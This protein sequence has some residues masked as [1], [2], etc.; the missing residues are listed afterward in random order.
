M[1]LK[2]SFTMQDLL[3]RRCTAGIDLGFTHDLTALSLW[4]PPETEDEK[5]KVLCWYWLPEH[6]AD[7]PRNRMRSE[8]LRWAKDPLARLELTPG[9]VTDHGYLQTRFRELFSLFDV[10]SLLY[11]KRGAEKTTQELSDGLI[12][13]GGSVLLQGTGVTRVEF[14]QGLA[15]YAEPTKE[16]ERLVVGGELEHDGNPLLAWQ[17]EHCSFVERDGL[18]MPVKPGERKN[19]SHDYRTVD[20]VQATIM[21]LAGSRAQTDV[22]W[23][24]PGSLS[25]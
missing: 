17:M 10:Q 22:N 3:G 15:N 19:R 21:A 25:L 5:A 4:F 12:G 14:Q 20:G 1:Q 7:N 18:K 9:E 13:P 23:Y 2:S 16:F 24:T 8:F 11:D 6:V